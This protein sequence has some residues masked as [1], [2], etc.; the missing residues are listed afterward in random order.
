MTSQKTPAYRKT[1]ETTTFGLTLTTEYGYDENGFFHH[2]Y[3][4]E[5]DNRM[6]IVHA[7]WDGKPNPK[8]WHMR[9]SAYADYY[10]NG[11]TVGRT[12][13]YNHLD[14][15]QIKAV[16]Y[17]MGYDTDNAA[18]KARSE[19]RKAKYERNKRILSEVPTVG[20]EEIRTLARQIGFNITDNEDADGLETFVKTYI[21]AAN[22]TN[23]FDL[24][25]RR[26]QFE[27]EINAWMDKHA[28]CSPEEM[29]SWTEF[30]ELNR[31]I[32][33]VRDEC[34]RRTAASVGLEDRLD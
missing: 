34:N 14:N 27:V 32:I 9:Q 23:L 8:D 33:A 30:C 21:A 4:Y 22:E 25:A 10:E 15:A 3:T 17:V 7:I 5:H 31:Q 29:P 13:T 1:V 20:L 19:I 6:A 12:R 24:L 16:R 26:H 18:D 2:D 11:Q 28:G